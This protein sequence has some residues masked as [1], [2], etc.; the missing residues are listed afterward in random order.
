MP[1]PFLLTGIRPDADR[2]PPHFYANTQKISTWYFPLEMITDSQ[3]EGVGGPVNPV[4]QTIYP[5]TVV[6]AGDQ[7]P[8]GIMRKGEVKFKHQII[9]LLS[10]R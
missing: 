9:P 8:P 4:E 7:T 5:G 1:P 2:T 10:Q 3:T 6:E